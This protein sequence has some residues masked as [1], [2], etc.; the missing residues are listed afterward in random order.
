MGLHR[1]TGPQYETKLHFLDMA[2]S[3]ASDADARGEDV[4][5]RVIDMLYSVRTI[6]GH[7]AGQL[8]ALQAS[9]DRLEGK[10]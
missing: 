3:T 1:E 8:E 2:L 10:K 6:L 5:Q 9:V 7:M 4:S